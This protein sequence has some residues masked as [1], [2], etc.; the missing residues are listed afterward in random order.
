[1]VSLYAVSLPCGN[2]CVPP[3]HSDCPPG[4]GSPVPAS[5]ADTYTIGQS[6]VAPAEVTNCRVGSSMASGSASAAATIAARTRCVAVRTVSASNM[7]VEAVIGAQPP[8]GAVLWT[9]DGFPLTGPQP[10]DARDVTIEEIVAISATCRT[11]SHGTLVRSRNV[12]AARYASAACPNVNTARST[13]C[14][15]GVRDCEIGIV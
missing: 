5:I 14:R 1:M 13:T 12:F 11:F 15:T 7:T 6:H 2:V 10:C 9:S 4:S 8:A 3:D